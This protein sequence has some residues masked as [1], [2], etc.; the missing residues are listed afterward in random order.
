MMLAASGSD[1]SRM[2]AMAYDNAE[3]LRRRFGRTPVPVSIEAPANLEYSRTTRPHR[4]CPAGTQSNIAELETSGL[5]P[6][7][8]EN[9]G[10]DRS[11]AEILLRSY[12]HWTGRDLVSDQASASEQARALFLAPFVV[13]AHGTEADPIFRYGNA[14]ALE[15]FGMSW[16][17]FTNLPSRLSAEPMAQEDRARFLERAARDGFVDGYSGIRI[18]ASGRRFQIRDATLWNLLD[19]A[20]RPCGQAAT[21]ARWRF[22]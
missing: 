20:D 19:I 17:E 22:L 13:V 5:R 18:S 9:N 14:T 4:P 6:A 8:N 2:G 16:D 12:R 21:F 3:G 7:P 11:F 1:I 10:Y 15:L